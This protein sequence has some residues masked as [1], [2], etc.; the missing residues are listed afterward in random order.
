MAVGVGHSY[1]R[2]TEKCPAAKWHPGTGA[3]G[4]KRTL[5]FDREK[6]IQDQAVG[7]AAKRAIDEGADDVRARTIETAHRLASGAVELRDRAR[8][9]N[10]LL[11]S[12]QG[13]F[14]VDHDRRAERDWP[15]PDLG[16][17]TPSAHRTPRWHA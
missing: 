17:H 9:S 10:V 1:R 8:T 12:G 2:R 16:R 4:D 15:Q 5:A 13:A 11:M 14:V 7:D 6:F 3:A